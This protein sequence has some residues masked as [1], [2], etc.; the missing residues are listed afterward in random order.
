MAA[1]RVIPWLLVF[2]FVAALIGQS[3]A[4]R[5]PEFFKIRVTWSNGRIAARSRRARSIP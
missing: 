4:N 2:G 3:R 1:I 5:G